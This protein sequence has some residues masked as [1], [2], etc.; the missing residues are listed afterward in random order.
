[1]YT[2]F[3]HEIKFP[4]N[5]PAYGRVKCIEFNIIYNELRSSVNIIVF[6]VKT[7][8]VGAKKIVFNVNSIV[9]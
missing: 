9:S 1:M 7:K 3:L 2:E 8:V 6:I 4:L 5:R